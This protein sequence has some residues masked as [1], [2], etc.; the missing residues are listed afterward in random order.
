VIAVALFVLIRSG[1]SST[2]ARVGTEGAQHLNLSN[3][4]AEPEAARPRHTRISCPP[5]FWSPE[6]HGVRK[7]WSPASC[8]MSLSQ[9]YATRPLTHQVAGIAT[10]R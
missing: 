2:P 3:G 5:R 4:R 9:L 10:L 8:T 1:L 7:L 6:R